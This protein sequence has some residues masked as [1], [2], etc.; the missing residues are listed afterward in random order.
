MASLIEDETKEALTEAIIQK[1]AE[2]V[3][4]TGC[5]VQ[6]DSA[7]AFVAMEK[8]NDTPHSP[9]LKHKIV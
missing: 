9:L 3:P 8:E 7:P 1:I 2:F 4:H 6:T 5:V